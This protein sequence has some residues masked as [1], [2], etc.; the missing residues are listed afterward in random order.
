MNSV[1]FE[2]VEPNT[3]LLAKYADKIRSSKPLNAKDL[4]RYL[5]LMEDLPGIEARAVLQPS[6][7]EQGASDVIVTITEKNYE[8]SLTVDNRGSRFL[9]QYQGGATLDV[10]NVFGWFERTRIRVLQ[11]LGEKE[12]RFGEVVHEQ[13]IGDEGTRVALSA[14]HTAT[15]PGLGL[16]ALDVEGQSRTYSAAVKHPF[17]RSRQENIYGTFEF[18]A[19]DTDVTALDD[20]LYEDRTRVIKATGSYDFI[21]R[22]NAVNQIDFSAS[23]GLGIFNDDAAG[24]LRS[25]ADG[26][27][28]FFKLNLDASHLH[29]IS[30]PISAYVAVSGQWSADPLL[31]SE[32]FAIGGSQFGSAYDPSEVTGDHGAAAK[33][34]LQY[35]GFTDMAWLSNYQFYGFYDIGKAWNKGNISG[36]DSNALAST[37]LG[38]RFNMFEDFSGDLQVALPLNH[39]VS[40]NGEDG[41][42]PRAFF[43]VA[44]RF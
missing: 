23:K 1:S 14:S 36:D 11:T 15:D 7:T 32:E 44:Y 22:F 40:A 31:A 13:A 43:S 9:G 26:K 10:N 21:D 19:R 34:E 3:G 29:T 41:R 2:G 5:L 4:E 35:N 6:P 28:S 20:R 39:T 33:L 12:L 38:V 16:R 37:G 17:V 25:R 18:T 42:A 30:G 8:G 24:G 27:T